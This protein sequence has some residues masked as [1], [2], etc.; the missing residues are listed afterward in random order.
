MSSRSLPFLP[1]YTLPLLLVLG[2]C[3]RPAAKPITSTPE[4]PSEAVTGAVPEDPEPFGWAGS[5][6]VSAEEPP[7]EGGP[8]P[9]AAALIAECEEEF[10]RGVEAYRNEK[11]RK[12]MR[13][14]D[15]A[16][17]RL[18]HAPESIRGEPAVSA[19]LQ[20]I[21]DSIHV[22][23]LEAYN[24][25]GEHVGASSD[26][27]KN[28]EA[29]LSP[30]DAE[31]QRRLVEEELSKVF[32]DL[33]IVVND[34]VLALIE[35]YQTRLK[36]QYQGG[37]RRS[38]RYMKM[39]RR[40]LAEEGVPQD[41]VYMVQVESMF[42]DRAYSRAHAK[43]LWQFIASTGRSYG[44][45]RNYWIDERADPVKATRAAARHM[46]DLHE[47]FGDWYLAM[48][49]YNAGPGKV[50]RAIRRTGS[51]DFWRLSRSRYLRRETRNYIPAI[52]ASI[53]IMKDPERY[54]FKAEYDP[55]WRYET[56]EVDSATELRVIGE[57]AGVSAKE[58][59]SY[60]LELRRRM[61]PPD[62]G[63]YEIKLPPGTRDRFAKAFGELPRDKRLTYTRHRVR[64]GET[65]ST[66]ARRYNTNVRALQKTNNIRNRHRISVG[67]VLTVPL[68][69]AG[70][71]HAVRDA[72]ST[73]RNRYQR[74]QRIIH[75]VR[76]G[77]TLYGIARRYRTSVRAIQRWNSLGSSTL[78]HP[79]RRLVV[80][81]RTTKSRPSQVQVAKSSTPRRAPPS[82]AGSTVVHRVRRGETLWS[83]ARR[84]RTSV[85]KICRWNG[86]SAS[87]V[88]MPG[89]TLSIYTQ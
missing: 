53:L 75:R 62:S 27:L 87:A 55:E 19:A 60:N 57:C 64:K 80:Y 16:V 33:P 65:L 71:I 7:L 31:R 79:G 17:H 3:G 8:S 10:A 42:K 5:A 76:R 39:M 12:A 37:I 47:L 28:I 69:P 30:A 74:G 6:V 59:G 29:F 11:F 46:R 54:G 1:L 61:T 84:Y 41:L 52:I 40:I 85:K 70:E 66:I 82:G 20:E 45:R 44:L 15:S 4:P 83:I 73:S 63:V 23:E 51:R 81:Y 68:G 34:K 43:G 86:I 13:R 88:L 26:E 36:D 78:L 9:A 25:H 38:G 22:L 89:T 14:F 21:V 24:G 2:G 35:V 18:L 56:A 72:R 48:A 67:Q 49:A 58:M 77:Q 32:S 50:K